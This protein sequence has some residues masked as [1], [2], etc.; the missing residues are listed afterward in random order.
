MKTLE[1]RGGNPSD[2]GEKTGRGNGRAELGWGHQRQLEWGERASSAKAGRG[3]GKAGLDRGILGSWVGVKG[4]LGNLGG[5]GGLPGRPRQCEKG[6]LHQ[7][8]H[9]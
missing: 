3:N 6:G 1:T 5:K 4:V 2:E 9:Q 7:A 8:K